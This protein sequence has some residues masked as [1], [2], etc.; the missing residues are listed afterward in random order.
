M[1]LGQM[2]TFTLRV[3]AISPVAFVALGYLTIVA[4]VV[5][6]D[7]LLPTYAPPNVFWSVVMYAAAGFGLLCFLLGAVLGVLHILYWRRLAESCFALI[8]LIPI[9]LAIHHSFVRASAVHSA[10]QGHAGDAAKPRA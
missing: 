6:Q 10:Q 8:L 4:I 7:Q 1:A 5:L 9:G 3:A 2:K